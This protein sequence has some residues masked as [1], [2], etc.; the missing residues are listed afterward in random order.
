MVAPST[1]GSYRGYWRIRNPSGVYLPILNGYQ[2]RS[3][4]VDI[5]VTTASSG[6]DLYTRANVAS[7]SSGGGAITFGGPD[8][9]PKGSA[10]YKDG[11]K[12]EDGK[13]YS[14]IVGTYPQNV[15]DGYISGRYPPYTV[16]AGEHF[17]AKIGFT[18]LAD[19]TCGS[20]NVKFQLAYK[21]GATTTTLGEWTESCDGTLRTIDVD[22][23][24]LKGRSVEII[25]MVLANGSS[26]GDS[27]VWLKPQ[28]AL[29]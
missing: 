9:D 16:V 20:G 1:D 10:M 8:S 13:T 29:P 19:G 12:L 4:F 23:T 21:D 18:T 27:A 15:N 22:L 26:A 28:I 11:Q 25:L 6:Y 14:K 2:N 17:T 7:W 5:K 24:S 3:F